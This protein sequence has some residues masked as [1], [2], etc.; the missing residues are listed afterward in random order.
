MDG[1][2][3]EKGENDED[4]GRAPLIANTCKPSCKLNQRKMLWLEGMLYLVQI[5][6]KQKSPIFRYHMSYVRKPF[7]GIWCRGMPRCQLVQ[8]HAMML[9]GAEACHDAVWC[10]GLPWCSPLILTNR[11]RFFTLIHEVFLTIAARMTLLYSQL[12]VVTMR[13]LGCNAPSMQ[14]PNPLQVQVAK[15]PRNLSMAQAVQR[16]GSDDCIK[17]AKL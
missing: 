9:I 10:R 16:Y 1:R 17:L 6:W 15:D 3:C 4:M 14:C 12:G 8:R 7:V 13:R 5:I 2:L 11:L